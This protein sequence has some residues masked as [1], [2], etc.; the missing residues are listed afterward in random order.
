MRT[1]KSLFDCAT[2]N[3]Q[4]VPDRLYRTTPKVQ[5]G[6]QKPEGSPPDLV[7]RTMCTF[8][9]LCDLPGARQLAE[10]IGHSLRVRSPVQVKHRENSLGLVD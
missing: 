7:P 8:R 1:R 3:F 5:H 6:T 10:Q 2:S 9:G 4:L